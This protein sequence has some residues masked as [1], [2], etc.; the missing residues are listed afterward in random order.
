MPYFPASSIDIYLLVSN[1]KIWYSRVY[2]LYLLF[3]RY[4]TTR[5]GIVLGELGLIFTAS[6]FDNFCFTCYGTTRND[7][8]D[9]DLDI[10]YASVN[11]L[12]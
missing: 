7:T 8:L 9:D 1:F 6:I 12:K 10:S 11:D 4:C 2:F 5:T 3:T